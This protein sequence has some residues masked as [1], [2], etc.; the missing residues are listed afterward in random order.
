MG[1]FF[2]FLEEVADFALET[3]WELLLGIWES[4]EKTY[5]RVFRFSTDV[6]RWLNQPVR[7]RQ[8]RTRDSLAVFIKDEL[9]NGNFNVVSCL[10]NPDEEEIYDARVIE[11]EE[12]DDETLHHFDDEEV[13]VLSYER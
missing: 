11:V 5:K 3:L 9:D 8:M 10:Y 6:L 13:L 7:A 2:D 12:L 4:V 1:G